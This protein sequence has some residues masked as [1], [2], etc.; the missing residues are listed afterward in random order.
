MEQES[1]Y[2]HKETLSS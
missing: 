2:P 1:D